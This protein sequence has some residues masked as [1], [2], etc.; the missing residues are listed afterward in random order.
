MSFNTSSAY[1]RQMTGASGADGL[2]KSMETQGQTNLDAGD[3]YG[4]VDRV[5]TSNLIILFKFY[6]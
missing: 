6:F 2:W 3:Q 4:L 5:F 1:P